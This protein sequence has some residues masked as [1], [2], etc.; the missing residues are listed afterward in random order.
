MD[1]NLAGEGEIV[2]VD[3][4]RLSYRSQG[5]GSP[6]VLLHGNA[7]FAQDFA[8]VLDDLAGRGY[9]AI[10]FDRPGHG[11]SERSE[12]ERVSVE[13]QAG[14]IREAL[15]K[16]G[17]E[18][19]IMVGHSWSGL[20]VLAY[21]LIY[22]ADVS[23]A[24][25]LAPAVYREAE[26]FTIERTI[27]EIPGLGDLILR[28]S[29]PVIDWEIRR[30]LDLAFA[31]AAIPED[32]LALATTVWNNPAQIK[33]IMHD[34]AEFNPAVERFS[35]RYDSVRAPVVIVTGD[36]D[37]LVKAENHA[38]PLH[39]AISHSALCVLPGTGHMVPHTRPESVFEAIRLIERPD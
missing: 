37:K 12:N 35:P 2:V 4:L 5:E 6:V 28:L 20:L 34:E 36:S 13:A 25:L 17:V 23:G 21:S 33:A 14:L 3:G 19:P 7:G 18:R 10:A 29:S 11:H 9:Q 22:D 32:Y 26:Q 27:A 31:P 15:A 24:V 16:I 39:K 8:A 38:V 1:F 30:D